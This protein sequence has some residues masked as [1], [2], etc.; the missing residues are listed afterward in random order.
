MEFP[1]GD[2][3][4]VFKLSSRLLFHPATVLLCIGGCEK[5]S[6]AG[7][8][9]WFIIRFVGS[10]LHSCITKCPV[11]VFTLD[12][13]AV[14]GGILSS[15]PVCL[16]LKSLISSFKFAI[17]LSLTWLNPPITGSTNLF[18][19]FQFYSVVLNFGRVLTVLFSAPI[20]V[21]FGSRLCHTVVALWVF[22]F[23][24][25][26]MVG[27]AD[28]SCSGPLSTQPSEVFIWRFIVWLS[29]VI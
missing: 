8:L 5:M 11:V 19:F 10:W 16:S 12:L 13:A 24:G 9:G 1:L 26:G 20:L 2:G 21:F 22:F 15:E 6:L 23:F 25:G 17:I 7:E 28:E 27:E 18:Y 4:A 29:F 14:D 3:P